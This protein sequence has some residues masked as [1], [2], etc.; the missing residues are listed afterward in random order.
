MESLLLDKQLTSTDS[1]LLDK[2]LDNG[3]TST[4]TEKHK[5]YHNINHERIN[6][7]N[8]LDYKK[9]RPHFIITS[10]STQNTLNKYKPNTNAHK[11]YT[12]I[13]TNTLKTNTILNKPNPQGN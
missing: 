5:R 13:Q 7:H 9:T 4:Y 10:L 8:R 12:T 6:A 11:K 3:K 1:E 2:Q